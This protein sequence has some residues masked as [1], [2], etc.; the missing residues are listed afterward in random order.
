MSWDAPFLC[1][2]CGQPL[3]VASDL[4]GDVVCTCGASLPVVRGVPLYL[5]AADSRADARAHVRALTEATFHDPRRYAAMIRAR[6]TVQSLIGKR[7]AEIGIAPFVQ[8]RTVLDVG[9]GPNL[10]LPNAENCHELAAAYVGV[11]SS[12]EFALTARTLHDDDHHRFA[13]ADARRLPFPDDSFDTVL[14]S[15]TIHHVEGSSRAVVDELQRVA[16][17]HLVI[18]DHVR[19]TRALPRRIQ[20]LYWKLF[21]GGANYLTRAQWDAA[22]DGVCVEREVRS[23]ALFGHVVKFAC[24]VNASPASR[25]TARGEG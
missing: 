16:R 17:Q 7:D 1:N 21:D 25:Y 4:T 12:A 5:A 19:E 15:F 8:G 24:E 18:Y 11:D 10:S 9:C 23:G 13:Q 22:L 6:V 3:T 14:A 2:A 20:D